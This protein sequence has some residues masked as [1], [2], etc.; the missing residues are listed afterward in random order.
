MGHLEARSYC[1][2]HL[3][4]VEGGQGMIRIPLGHFVGSPGVRKGI[5]FDAERIYMNL[6]L[7]FLFLCV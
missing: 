1:I 6:N 4:P 7:H 2:N 5:H 3:P